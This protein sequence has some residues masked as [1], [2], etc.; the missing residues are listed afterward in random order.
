[1]EKLTQNTNALIGSAGIVGFL[2]L[3]MLS[4]DYRVDANFGKL[5]KQLTRPVSM[6]LV[7][8]A[9][10][11]IL[12]SNSQ[13]PSRVS[14]IL[15]SP[16]A[17]LV[18]LLLLGAIASGDIESALASVSFVLLVIQILRTPDERARNPYII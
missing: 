9:A 6:A 4:G 11:F 17:R 13:L 1:M 14:K 7:V 10:T 5:E 2:A 8:V 12:S 16:I 18:T 15:Q 3:K